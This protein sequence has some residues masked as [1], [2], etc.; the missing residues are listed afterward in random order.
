MS[1]LPFGGG[2]DR[3]S[4]RPLSD[5]FRRHADSLVRAERSPLYVELMRAAAQDID[6][7]GDVA[8]LF[9]DVFAPP[10][11]VPQLRLMA[12]LHHLVL[13][14]MAPALARFYPSAGG[15]L[16]PDGVW[17]VAL[18][19]IRDNFDWLGPR[20]ARTVQTNEPGR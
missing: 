10:G 17:P 20:V 11:A 6:R 2:D 18:E 8:A 5:R 1:K 12:A 3:S 4:A 7:G 14:G 13:S 15:D 19:A 16:P 9:T